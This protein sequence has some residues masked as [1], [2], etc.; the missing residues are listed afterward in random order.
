LIYE[1]VK[2][3]KH[4]FPNFYEQLKNVQDPRKQAHYKIEEIIFAAISMFLFKTG[5]RNNF[6]NF[7][8]TGKFKK[9]FN[10]A[11]GF[12]LPSLDAVS[13]VIKEMS[14]LELENIKISMLKTLIEK[15]V[16]HKWRFK[17][18]FLIATD[19]TGI[20]SYKT[21]HCDDCLY[22]ETKKGVK[23]YYHKVLEAK[24]VTSNG[25]SISICTVWIDNEDTNN[26]IYDKQGCE[27]KAFK[28]LAKKLKKDFP[29]LPICFCV[30][31]LYPNNSF[32]E[33]C[34]NNNW[35]FIVT[36]KDGNL[37]GLW[38]KI[39]LVNR[40]HLKNEYKEDNTLF[41]QDI[42]WIN[43]TEHNGFTHNWIQCK[44][45]QINSK[46]EQKK[47]RFVYITNISIDS[48]NC[49]DVCF[50]GRLRWKIEKQGFD[51]QKNHGYNIKHKYCRKSYRGMKN[52]Y[53][54]CQIAHIIN[55]LV[56]RNKNYK[57]QLKGKMTTIFNWEMMLAFM[58]FGYIKPGDIQRINEHKYQIQYTE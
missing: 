38:K 9:N 20:S 7:R 10:K 42:Q 47:F 56:E 37:K 55:Q 57:N 50:S 40:E 21:K 31:G 24:I 17:G 19:G 23:T 52:Y 13:D 4:H 14:E 18:R 53:Q 16:L 41:N 25:F 39:R 33:I 46:G 11:F 58:I 3:V 43:N 8:K 2:I 32:F 44:E 49:I 27:R 12:R 6:D 26:G 28:K 1:I 5:S 35:D 15:K 48:E 54:C 34:E 45:L 30:D 29:R 22:T 51:Q 36:L